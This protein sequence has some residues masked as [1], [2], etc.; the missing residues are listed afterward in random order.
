MLAFLFRRLALVVPT[1]LGITLLV[2]ALIRLIPG[3][4]VEAMSGE[5]GMA[6]ERYHRLIHEFGLDRPLPV[7][8]ADYVWRALHGDLGLSIVTH[9]PVFSEF[10]ARFPAT[11]WW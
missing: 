7:Q 11:A 5:R 3:D 4:P 8:Y 10:A 9:E 2:F 1:F 6:P